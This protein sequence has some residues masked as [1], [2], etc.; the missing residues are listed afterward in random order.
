MG[1]E[2]IGVID[3][4]TTQQNSLQHYLEKK[5]INKNNNTA[6]EQP[7]AAAWEKH[8]ITLSDNF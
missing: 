8:S 2:N 6:S 1:Q 3:Y 7:E 4:D 5:R